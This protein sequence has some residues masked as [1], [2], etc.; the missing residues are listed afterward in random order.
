M[1]QLNLPPRPHSYGEGRDKDPHVPQLLDVHP[2]LQ[3][4][5]SLNAAH[6][7]QILQTRAMTISGLCDWLDALQCWKVTGLSDD[8]AIAGS[9][10]ASLVTP[11]TT[12]LQQSPLQCALGT[13]TWTRR[14][15]A[16]QQVVVAVVVV[17][18]AEEAIDE[19][20]AARK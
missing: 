14:M 7:S 18:A 4:E 20:D 8:S 15:Q 3:L 11:T 1:K 13:S 5:D 12:T 2:W 16:G 17:A 9:H 6:H 19:D 10:L